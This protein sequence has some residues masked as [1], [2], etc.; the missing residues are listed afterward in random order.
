MRKTFEELRYFYENHKGLCLIQTTARFMFDGAIYKEDDL[1]TILPEKEYTNHE[2]IYDENSYSFFR[3][4]QQRGNSRNGRSNSP[5]HNS[6]SDS[7]IIHQNSKYCELQRFWPRYSCLRDRARYERI[8][9][10]DAELSNSSLK[11]KHPKRKIDHTSQ[12]K[13]FTERLLAKEYLYEFHGR[14]SFEIFQDKEIKSEYLYR[15][16]YP[17]F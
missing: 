4:P 7:V 16:E 1:V 12:T 3:P 9:F 11:K 2:I 6:D 15:I 8:L 17:L 10:C 5:H 13:R 14:D